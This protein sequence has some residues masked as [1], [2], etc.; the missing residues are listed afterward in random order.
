MPGALRCVREALAGALGAATLAASAHAQQRVDLPGALSLAM[1][2]NRELARAALAAESARISVRQALSDFT[3]GVKPSGNVGMTE[4]GREATYALEAGRKLIWGSEVSVAG[5]ASLREDDETN[6]VRRLGLRLEIQQPLFRN[7]GSLIHGE[8]IRLADSAVKRARR[9]I[10][11]QKADLAV[12]VAD[13]YQRI[14]LLEQQIRADEAALARLDRLCRL[15]RTRERQGR[16]TR[17]DTLRMELQRGQAEL[18]LEN[19]REQRLNAGKDF[20]EL[21]GF[22]P[23]AEF[24]LEPVPDLVF[25]APSAEEAARVALQNRLD[26]AQAL[27]DQADTVRGV[28]IARRSLWPDIRLTTRYERYGEGPEVDDAT[29]FDEDLWFVGWTSDSELNQA[30]SRLVVTRPYWTEAARTSG[31]RSS[32]WR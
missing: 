30:K 4:D 13:T 26:Y 9:A 1:A 24:A 11:M 19:S 27:Q 5:G 16:A 2:R 15:T 25:D 32:R 12:Q 20:A 21:L 17:V 10:E 8:P 31:F 22:A 3:V 28:R 18:G 6:D 29:G 23:D 7:W 14:L